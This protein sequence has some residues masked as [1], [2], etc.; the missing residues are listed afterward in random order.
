MGGIGRLVR[1]IRFI[2][3]TI[4]RIFILCVVLI[5]GLFLIINIAGGPLVSKVAQ[6]IFHKPLKIEK[7]YLSP[8]RIRAYGLSYSDIVDVGRAEL[9][10][11]LYPFWVESVVLDNIRFRWQ[12]GDR[13]SNKGSAKQFSGIEG[14]AVVIGLPVQ[15]I[16]AND[17]VLEL[18]TKEGT[19]AKVEFSGRV[20][21]PSINIHYYDIDLSSK[22]Y[23]HQYVGQGTVKGWLDWDN[24]NAD[25]DLDLH[26]LDLGLLEYFFNL[27]D[28]EGLIDIGIKARA[29][30]NKLVMENSIALHKFSYNSLATKVPVISSLM[31]VVNSLKEPDLK[32]NFR[33][34][35]KLDSPKFNF[36]RYI[37]S[38]LMD[39]KKVVS[40]V[41]D[42]DDEKQDKGEIYDIINDFVGVVGSV[43]DSV[44]GEK[45]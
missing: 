35:T 16:I 38:A 30:A 18:Y 24:K 5:V 15:D 43:I 23:S 41:S 39:Q 22:I 17:G 21:R 27:P 14:L 32:F 29:K 42:S 36:K 34:T 37:L 31:P 45:K 9:I 1:F 2:F 12:L 19:V 7:L 20:Y 3:T 13:H 40:N 28:M 25:I 44:V 11:H 4:F 10:Y 26:S 6:T 8:R 33:V